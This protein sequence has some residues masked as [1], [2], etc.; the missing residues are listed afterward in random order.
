[1]DPTYFNTNVK[2]PYNIYH[3]HLP[4][5]ISFGGEED[6]MFDVSTLTWTSKDI[7]NVYANLQ[8][9]NIQPTPNFETY[10]FNKNGTQTLIADLILKQLPVAYILICII[11]HQLQYQEPLEANFSTG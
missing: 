8:K 10:E 3:T 1:M 7:P 4:P 5:G 9:F 6:G 2:F 11:Y